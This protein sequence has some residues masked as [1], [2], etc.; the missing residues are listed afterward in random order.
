[1]ESSQVSDAIAEL[2]SGFRI[3]LMTNPLFLSGLLIDEG[4]HGPGHSLA[5]FLSGPVTAPLLPNQ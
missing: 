5:G 3:S 2:V 1:M 4:G